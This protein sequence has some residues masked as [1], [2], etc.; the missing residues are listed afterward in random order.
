MSRRSLVFLAATFLVSLAGCSPDAPGGSPGASASGGASGAAGS[1]AG[2]GGG[3]AASV[4]VE[5]PEPAAFGGT[6]ACPA[7]LPDAPD[8][9]SG[10]G[11]AS[12]DR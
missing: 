10:T 4:C 11:S 8:S 9:M 3:G 2:G 12:L 6:D 1:G 7:A 5:S